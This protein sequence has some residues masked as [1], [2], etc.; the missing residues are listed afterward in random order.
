[1]KPNL[2][3]PNSSIMEITSTTK[4]KAA[5]KKKKD[6]QPRVEGIIHII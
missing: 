4:I 6:Q 5:V 3:R 1:M 2:L